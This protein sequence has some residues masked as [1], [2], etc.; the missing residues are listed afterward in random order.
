M[1]QQSIYLESGGG[2]LFSKDF[3]ICVKNPKHAEKVTIKKTFEGLC[4]SEYNVK[5]TYDADVY[6]FKDEYT[7]GHDDSVS[8]EI[9][10][11]QNGRE[12]K[13]LDYGTYLDN[14]K[15]YE[16]YQDM[17]QFYLEQLKLLH[18]VY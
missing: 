4:T 17:K 12:E 7:E 1:K 6:I 2:T 3:H 15:D 9:S 18:E 11:Y 14:S 10:R 5:F 8:L 16:E 13:I